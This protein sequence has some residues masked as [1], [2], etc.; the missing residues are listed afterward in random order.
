[1]TQQW[2][3]KSS[4]AIKK[5]GLQIDLYQYHIREKTK[6]TE[7]AISTQAQKDTI[8]SDLTVKCTVHTEFVGTISKTRY[9]RKLHNKNIVVTNNFLQMSPCILNIW[10]L[11]PM[12]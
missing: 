12:K 11:S 7:I 4:I 9:I 5:F 10:T 3:L 1:M 2:S 6:L 8:I